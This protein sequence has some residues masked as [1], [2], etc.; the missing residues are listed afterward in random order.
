MNIDKKGW[1]KICAGVVAAIIL[2]GLIIFGVYM[3]LNQKIR[4]GY[5]YLINKNSVIVYNPENKNLDAVAKK[6]NNIV[7]GRIVLLYKDK[8]PVIDM[9]RFDM[10]YIGAAANGENIDKVTKNFIRS[11][12]KKKTR[13][14]LPFLVRKNLQEGKAVFKI[15]LNAYGNS[16]KNPLIYT[17]DGEPAFRV[18]TLMWMNKLEFTRLELMLMSKGKNKK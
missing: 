17:G 9:K 18:N 15:E 7:N 13:V 6:L 1:I 2:I 4:P 10:I 16:V 5:E 11:I 14:I 12:P 8:N 3:Y